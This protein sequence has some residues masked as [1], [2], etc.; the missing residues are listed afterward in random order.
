MSFEE[1]DSM[2]PEQVEW[3]LT[4]P[5]KQLAMAVTREPRLTIHRART[6]AVIKSTG[7]ITVLKTFFGTLFRNSFSLSCYQ[8]ERTSGN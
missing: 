5:A 2:H 1:L 8:T 7:L 3:K 4:N 6:R